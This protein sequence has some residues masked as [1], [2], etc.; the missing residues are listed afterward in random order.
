MKDLK[1]TTGVAAALLAAGCGQQDNGWTADRDTAVCVDQQGKRVP[2]DQ[3]PGQRHAGGGMGSAFLWYYLG[4]QSA[5]PYYGEPVRGGSFTPAAG[6]SYFRAPAAT[7]F[8]RSAA[9]ARGGF[10]SSAR[11]FG[12][13]G[14]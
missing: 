12:G 2:D 4:R 5:L 8:T 14:E 9:V 13:A 1:I 11:S 6:H 10:G 3:C 7:A